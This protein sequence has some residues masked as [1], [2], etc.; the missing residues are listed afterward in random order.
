MS[1]YAF[2]PFILDPRERRLTRDGHRLAVPGK[3]W[4]ILVILAEAGGRLVPHETLRA[5]LWP[6]VVVEDRTLTV[7]MSTL[8][9]ALGDGSPAEII[10]TVPR[11]GYR[12]AAAGAHRCR[13]GRRPRRA[14]IAEATTLA[15]RPFATSDLAEADSYLGVGIADAVS[16]AL[17]GGAWP[18]RVAGRCRRTTWPARARSAWGTCWKAPCSAATRACASP[19]A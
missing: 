12:L 5:E 8:R 2:G 9:K 4:R 11:A 13:A 16:T 17:G 7:H 10:E 15:V 6:N 3:A 1:V 19:P 18:C 14:P